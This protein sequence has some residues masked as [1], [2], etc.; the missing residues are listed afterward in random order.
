KILTI[1]VMMALVVA[2]LVEWWIVA[3][4]M[5]RDAAV[6]GLRI[7]ASS[8]DRQMQ[9]TTLAKWKTASQLVAITAILI[10][11]SAQTVSINM[12]G[13][14]LMTETNLRLLFNCVIG[15]SMILAVISG[16]RYFAAGEGRYTSEFG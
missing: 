4:M 13:V 7:Y 16:V 9:T 3:V 11:W 10:L 5:V 15:I 2:G 14:S 6:T 1:A 12:F 8:R